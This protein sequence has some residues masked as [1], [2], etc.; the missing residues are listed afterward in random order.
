MKKLFA[1]LA[2]SLLLFATACATVQPSPPPPSVT[3]SAEPSELSPLEFPPEEMLLTNISAG[4]VIAV[5]ETIEV[6]AGKAEA[7]ELE[8]AGFEDISLYIAQTGIIG[9]VR[10]YAPSGEL[11]DEFGYRAPD[12]SYK[13]SDAALGTWKFEFVPLSSDEVVEIIQRSGGADEDISTERI[14]A[15]QQASVR[16]VLTTRPSPISVAAQINTNYPMELFALIGGETGVTVRENG[17]AINLAEPLSEGLHELTVTRL[18]GQAESAETRTQV[19]IDTVAPTITYL[20]ESFE[21]TAHGLLLS[22]EF[23]SDV[24]EIYLDGEKYISTDWCG[25]RSSTTLRLAAQRLRL[26]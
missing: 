3:P 1:V 24:V 23:S 15:A 16:A 5:H 7:I 11:F 21:T 25:S 2:A 9:S 19:L 8:T 12:E 26:Q 17:S 4:E 13:L 22:V 6:G 10:V 18:I 14:R 20:M